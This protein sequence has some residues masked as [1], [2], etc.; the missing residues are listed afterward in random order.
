M[1][2]WLAFAP[3]ARAGRVAAMN[4]RRGDAVTEA[5]TPDCAT[6]ESRFAL[7]YEVRS[8]P[9]ASPIDS[10]SPTQAA[11]SDS[12]VATDNHRRPCLRT[13]TI[14]WRALFQEPHCVSP[15]QCSRQV[16][17]RRSGLVPGVKGCAVVK[18]E[19]NGPHVPLFDRAV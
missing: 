8:P 1:K 16:K 4:G 5:K 19:I 6:S 3:C 17:G 14:W 12:I 2:T 15:S 18:Q 7:L 11:Q 9:F 13:G 10:V